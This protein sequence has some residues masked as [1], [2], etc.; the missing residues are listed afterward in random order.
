MK[1]SENKTLNLLLKKNKKKDKKGCRLQEL[2]NF[3]RGTNNGTI[4]CK[5]F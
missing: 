4:I 3:F 1:I 2:S 5:Y